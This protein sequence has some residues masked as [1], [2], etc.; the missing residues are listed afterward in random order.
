MAWDNL[1]AFFEKKAQSKAKLQEPPQKWIK[2][3]EPLASD[4]SRGIGRQE[5]SS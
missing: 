3:L 4:A 2:I 1:K 5:V